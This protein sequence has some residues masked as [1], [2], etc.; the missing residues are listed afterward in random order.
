MAVTNVR[1]SDDTNIP[2]TVSYDSEPDVNMAS[3]PSGTW[4]DEG[5]Q[6]WLDAGNTIQPH[7]QWY[8]MD[9]DQVKEAKYRENE[10][11]AN[12]E[13]DYAERRPAAGTVL[14][15]F[16]KNKEDRKRNSR[17]KKNGGQTDADDTLADHI[18]D[19]LDAQDN[20]DD[21]V[22][23]MTN[24]EDVKAWNPGTGVTWP[25]WNPA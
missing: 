10:Q 5:V 14:D 11:Y 23:A 3:Y 13:I 6:E 20:A 17:S 9:I 8:G 7:D 21:A 24:I 19:I 18:D 22:E 4:R 2:V 16:T 15:D 12:T 1:Y 25:T